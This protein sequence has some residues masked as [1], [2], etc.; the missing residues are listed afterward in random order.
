MEK[1][2]E[3]KFVYLA[4][5]IEN[6]GFDGFWNNRFLEIV[7]KLYFC[8]EPFPFYTNATQN[9]SKSTFATSPLFHLTSKYELTKLEEYITLEI[10][11]FFEDAL[12][13]SLSTSFIVSDRSRFCDF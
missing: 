12:P 6:R 7:Y 2:S 1:I 4:Q 11:P 9:V 13:C 8:L 10:H 5:I 3:L